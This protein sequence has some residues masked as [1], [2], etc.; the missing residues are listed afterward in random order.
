SDYYHFEPGRHLLQGERSGKTYRLADRIR[1]RVVRVDLDEKKI[2][3]E[4]VK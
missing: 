1:V 2:D 4:P 3:F